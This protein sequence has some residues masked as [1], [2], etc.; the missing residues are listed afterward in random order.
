MEISEGEDTS[1][2]LEKVY[3]G[4]DDGAEC[5]ENVTD[6]IIELGK[7]VGLDLEKNNIDELLESDKQ[8]LDDEG[9]IAMGADVQLS[10]DN[11]GGGEDGELQTGDNSEQQPSTSN[12]MAD[13]LTLNAKGLLEAF[14]HL[15]NFYNY[16][17]VCDPETER[18]VKVINGIKNQVNCYHMLLD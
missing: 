7:V 3:E 17:K 15:E 10:V 13:G 18:N 14:E 1:R 12:Y 6:E 2:C 8:L 9:L 16:I 5:N 4:G 11:I